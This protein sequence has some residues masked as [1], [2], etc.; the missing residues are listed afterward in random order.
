VHIVL[1]NEQ[2]HIARLNPVFGISLDITG[3]P[4]DEIPI[5]HRAVRLPSKEH[6]NAN[7]VWYL[8]VVALEDT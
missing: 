8:L 4:M 7:F 2:D 3:G 6:G 1:E 5:R